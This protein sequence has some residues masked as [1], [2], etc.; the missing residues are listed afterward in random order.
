MIAIVIS[1]QSEMGIILLIHHSKLEN[2]ILCF[3][4]PVHE[5]KKNM[6][7]P[8][9]LLA[10]YNILSKKL[11]NDQELIQPDPTSCPQKWLPKSFVSTFW[12]QFNTANKHQGRR[13]KERSVG[14]VSGNGTSIVFGP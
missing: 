4:E 11:N 5:R 6:R 13:K 10:Q 9:W 2:N 1:K 14:S 12:K 8:S 7:H 3:I